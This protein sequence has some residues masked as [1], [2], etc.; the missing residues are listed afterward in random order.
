MS[1][2]LQVGMDSLR[3]ADEDLLQG[4]PGVFAI[5]H[6]SAFG[7]GKHEDARSV[8][9]DLHIFSHYVLYKYV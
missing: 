8:A 9:K 2:S 7:W 6:I 3:A 4:N 1:T 5:R